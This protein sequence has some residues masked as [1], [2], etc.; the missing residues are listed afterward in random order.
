MKYNIAVIEGDGIYRNR[1]P[2]TESWSRSFETNYQQVI[3]G[4]IIDLHG[5]P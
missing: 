2:G 3:A 5:I 4:M 1:T